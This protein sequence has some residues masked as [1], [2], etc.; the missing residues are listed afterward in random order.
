MRVLYLKG[1]IF[2]IWVLFLQMIRVLIHI[3]GI[4]LLAAYDW[5]SWMNFTL[6]SAFWVSL[7]SWCGFCIWSNLVSSCFE[8]KICYAIR[9]LVRNMISDVGLAGEGCL[10]PRWQLYSE[11][12]NVW[13]SGFLLVKFADFDFYQVWKLCFSWNW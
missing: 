5:S 11:E 10:T 6:N 9:V 1:K 12:W 7:T 13:I 3:V 8:V 2:G 4:F